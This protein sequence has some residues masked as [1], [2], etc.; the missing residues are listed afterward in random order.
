MLEA[1]HPASSSSDIS[2]RNTSS[3]VLLLVFVVA[4]AGCNPPEPAAPRDAAPPPATAAAE[5]PASEDEAPVRQPSAA[6]DSADTQEPAAN[7]ALDGEGLRKFLTATGASRPIQFGM[8]KADALRMLESVQGAPPQQQ[9]ENIDC[10]AT[11]AVWADGL[12]VWFARDRFVGWSLAAAGS[13]LSTAGGL[14]L[15]TT[16]AELENGAS[17]A[18]IARSSLGE[19]FTA[20]EV[21]GLLDSAAANARVTNLWAGATC[22]AR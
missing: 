12:T 21:A 14:M 18:K 6:P 15:G 9:G 20:G 8:A 4:V 11:N 7:L 19:E 2:M 22:I 17:V 1:M 5:S 13:P 3:L 16:R 10:G